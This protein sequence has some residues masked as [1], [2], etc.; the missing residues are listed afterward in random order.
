[1]FRGVKEQIVQAPA[2]LRSWVAQA[3]NSV[4]GAGDVF[5]PTVAAATSS[6][7]CLFFLGGGGEICAFLVGFPTVFVWV[8]ACVFFFGGVFPCSQHL[9]WAQKVR[10]LGN[11]FPF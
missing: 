11:C 7:V 3:P 10:L 6:F 8:E 9:T 4:L 5:F 2:S 1:M